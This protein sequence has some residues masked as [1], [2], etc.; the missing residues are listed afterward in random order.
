MNKVSDID[1]TRIELGEM[2]DLEAVDKLVDVKDLDLVDAG[3]AAGDAA[4]GLAERGATVLGVEPDPVQAESNRS[5]S[6]TPRVTL[7]EAGAQALP[8]EDSSTDGVFLFRSLHHVP[9]DLMDQALNEAARVLKPE[10]FLFVAEPAMGCSFFWLM[11]PFHDESKMRTLAQ[12]ALDRTAGN[13][14]EETAKYR[15]VQR[16]KFADFDA[17]VDMF[18]GMSFNRITRKMMDLP[19]VRKNFDAARTNDGYVFE[20]PML[21]NMYRRPRG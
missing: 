21:I 12:E 10:G 7:L 9:E 15:C 8:A 2:S 16:P 5:K 19:K 18:T 14:F 17:F 4:R 3:C 20:Q 6:P 11:Q 13:L 1:N